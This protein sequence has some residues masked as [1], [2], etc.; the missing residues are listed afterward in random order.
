MAKGYGTPA[1][2]RRFAP[3]SLGGRRTRLL[4]AFLLEIRERTYEMQY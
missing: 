4:G 1:L 3:P 2:V